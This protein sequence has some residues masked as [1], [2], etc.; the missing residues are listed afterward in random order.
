[1]DCVTHRFLLRLLHKRCSA[2]IAATSCR[3]FSSTSKANLDQESIKLYEDLNK[4]IAKFK[5]QLSGNSRHTYLSRSAKQS[6]TKLQMAILEMKE[7]TKC[8]DGQTL[9][10]SVPSSI[11]LEVLSNGTAQSNPSCFI[12]TPYKTYMFNCP[13]GSS[14]LMMALHIKPHQ[15]NDVFVTSA[16]WDKFGGLNSFLMSREVRGNEVIR[17][18]SSV[19]IR[20]FFDCI[21][22]F[23]DSDTGSVKYPAQVEERS[24]ENG[25]YIDPALKVYY[26]PLIPSRSSS[27]SACGS[28]PLPRSSFNTIFR[29]DLAFLIELTEP[30]RRINAAKLIELGIP[31]GP[32]IASLKDGLEVTLDGRLIKPD[33]VLFPREQKE[34]PTV[35][36]VDCSGLAYLPSLLETPLLQDFIN[37]TRS[38]TYCVHFTP[39]NVFE[40]PDYRQWLSLFGD[41]KHII[42]NGS[43]PVLPHLEGVHRQQDLMRSIAPC[44]FPA[45]KPEFKG[46]IGQDDECEKVGNL[47]FARP[48]QRF[49]LRGKMNSSDVIFSN[50]SGSAYVERDLT[51]EATSKIENFKKLA[52]GVVE[53]DATPALLFL[54]TASA[55]PSKYRN[56]SS[57][58][59]KIKNDSY[60]M[61]DCGEGTYGQM[62]VHFG[63]EKCK[64]VLL[65]LHA[66]FI[67]HAHMDHVNGLYSILLR[68][69]DAFNEEGVSFRPIVIICCPNIMR[70]LD[71]YSRAFSDLSPLLL[72]INLYKKLK[73]KVVQRSRQD[74]IPSNSNTMEITTDVTDLLPVNLFSEERWGIRTIKAVQV[75]H[76]RMASGYI[77]TLTSGHKVV[78]SGDTKPCQLLAKQGLNADVLVHEATFEDGLEKDALAKKHST[79]HQA[80]NIGR[81]MKAKYIILTH[82]SSRY[83]KVPS[84][85]TYL[86]DVGN[87][88]VASDNLYIRFKDLHLLPKLIPIYRDLFRDELFEMQVK[89][90]QQRLRERQMED[91]KEESLKMKRQHESPE[92]S[93]D[94]VS[95]RKKVSTQ[96]TL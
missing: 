26:V 74:N 17:I 69:K 79:M 40:T 64:E 78:F 27:P 66:I 95:P 93:G 35:L 10:A 75:H 6:L 88:A 82:F 47:L 81:Q 60:I 83:A 39:Q 18:H 9:A 59:L 72:F 56:V 52:V 84:L 19:G 67:T 62:R 21:R 1:M 71:F 77:F 33:D 58:L 32:H 16:I 29:T 8:I 37:K 24:L 22:P 7:Q 96:L 45:L 92:N 55:T 43:G 70:T 31:N 4:R 5:L 86:D 2:L 76:T 12:R 49:I 15:I 51:E 90:D 91:S 20:Q 63:E 30:P 48:L 25:Q 44:F 57:Q 94:S 38:L 3:T 46:V 13:E 85:P 42:L 14:R 61:I 41:C 73:P 87:V 23:A 28:S 36:I 89:L 50:L 80:I 68:R 65:N 34:Q 53:S 54:G 11:S